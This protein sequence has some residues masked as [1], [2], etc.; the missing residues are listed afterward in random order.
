MTTRLITTQLQPN[1]IEFFFVVVV[2]VNIVVVVVVIVV[3]VAKRD[4]CP[5]VTTHGRCPKVSTLCIFDVCFQ[6]FG[7]F[8]QVFLETVSRISS[9]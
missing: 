4:W 5:H 9:L 2:V 1:Y 7:L 6:V 3:V 8:W